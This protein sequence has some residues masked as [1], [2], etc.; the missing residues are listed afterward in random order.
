[1][2]DRLKT[3]ISDKEPKIDESLFDANQV[4]SL[5]A[6]S[7]ALVY[8]MAERGQLP[9]VRWECPGEGRKKPRTTVRFKREDVFDFIEKHYRST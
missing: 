1:M 2:F 4:R 5:L 7:L 3:L 6:C 9:C 8:R